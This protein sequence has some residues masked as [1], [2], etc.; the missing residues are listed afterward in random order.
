ML[1]EMGPIEDKLY[2]ILTDVFE[3]ISFSI[4]NELKVSDGTLY[5]SLTIPSFITHIY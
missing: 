3:K 2:D 4:K 1:I 5:N